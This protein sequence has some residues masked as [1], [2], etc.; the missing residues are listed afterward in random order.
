MDYQV[1]VGNVGT[2][3]SGP[4]KTVAEAAYAYYRE[5]SCSSKGARCYLEDVTLM[6]DGEPTLEH[7]GTECED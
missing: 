7:F 6:V 2:V 4:D 5:M 3:Y 1:I